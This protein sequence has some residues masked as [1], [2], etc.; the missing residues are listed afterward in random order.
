MKRVFCGP[1]HS[2]KGV[3]NANLIDKMPTDAYTI[4]KACPDGEGTWSNSQNQNETEIVRKKGKY[5]IAYAEVLE[6]LKYISENDYNKIPKKYIAYFKENADEN[7]MFTYN[8]ALPFNKQD[9]S[10]DAKNLLA[11][12]DSFFI[13]D[14][15]KNTN[16]KIERDNYYCKSINIDRK[17]LS[18]VYRILEQY[19]KKDKI[20]NK[21]MWV[22]EDN[23]DKEYLDE[24]DNIFS[25]TLREDTKKV[26]TYIYTNFLSTS[27]ERENLKALEKIQH[28]QK[29]ISKQISI[30]ELNQM[31]ITND[32][33]KKQS[34]D[35]TK[36][37]DAMVE[38]KE[39]IFKKIIRKIKNIFKR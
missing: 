28:E 11:M 30:K 20:P 4:I 37:N 9:I 13:I 21:Y 6:V 18:E 38:Y 8:V 10:E 14:R 15:N 27:E 35:E 39:S 16:E 19:D 25:Q 12:I 24:I 23:M 17:A 31:F 2:G 22:I 26:I 29:T 3:F 32:M 7:C 34:K 1:P 33:N 36:T 5:S